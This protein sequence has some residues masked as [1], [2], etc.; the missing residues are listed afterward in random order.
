MKELILDQK[1]Y[2]HTKAHIL[3]IN[4]PNNVAF[5]SSLAHGT[6]PPVMEAASIFLLAS[7][8]YSKK[9]IDTLPYPF[10]KIFPLLALGTVY[11][12]V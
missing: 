12:Y 11:N 8:V 6:A 1:R 7:L 10:L 9:K 3:L 5:F 4:Y 2:C